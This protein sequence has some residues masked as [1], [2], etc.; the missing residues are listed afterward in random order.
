MFSEILERLSALETREITKISVLDERLSALESRNNLLEKEN[1]SLKERIKCLEDNKF[2]R[3][4]LVPPVAD[5]AVF[6]FSDKLLYFIEINIA[7]VEMYDSRGECL[8]LLNNIPI[9]KSRL[10]DICI[11]GGAKGGQGQVGLTLYSPLYIAKE[12]DGS[13]SFSI[14]AVPYG[15]ERILYFREISNCNYSVLQKKNFYI[16][17]DISLFDW[18]PHSPNFHPNDTQIYYKI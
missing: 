16:P 11:V 7:H 13:A 15:V 2:I 10:R 9:D 17:C 5:D 6:E 3:L 1:D 4:K 18:Q 8:L 12:S 14:E